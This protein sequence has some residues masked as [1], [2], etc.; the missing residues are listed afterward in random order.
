MGPHAHDDC[1]RPARPDALGQG[2]L[3]DRQRP[4]GARVLGHRGARAAARPRLRVRPRHH[5]GAARRVRPQPARDGAGPPR[6]RQVEP[7][8]A[9]GRAP[10]LAVRARQPR[11]PREP[12][13]PD[14]QGHDR[15]ARRQADHR[16]PARHPDVGAAAPVRARLRRVRR[17]PRRR[18][19]R[20]PARARGRGAADAA[21]PE[22]G[23]RAASRRSAC[24]PPP[25]RSA[26]AT[27]RAS[28]TARSR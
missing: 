13:G 8:R 27:P 25:T 20:H 23:D 1:P 24:S 10:Q 19:V 22:P 5:A 26:S 2:P 16:V 17:R 3:Q 14:R 21:R 15:P 12:H 4:P 7:R 18:D 28:I 6:H 11:R 9:G